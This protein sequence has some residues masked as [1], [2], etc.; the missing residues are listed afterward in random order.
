MQL[1][2]HEHEYGDEAGRRVDDKFCRKKLSTKSRTDSATLL[3]VAST[4]ES[5]RRRQ[6]TPLSCASADTAVQGVQREAGTCGR[7][8]GANGPFHDAS[9]APASC[10]RCSRCGGSGPAR[11]VAHEEEGYAQHENRCEIRLAS[12]SAFAQNVAFSEA[13]S[14]PG[15]GGRTCAEDCEGA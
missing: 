15:K 1:C 3:S 8:E 4:R 6:A 10:G 12:S 9:A 2:A 7:E 11:A 13:T 5:D 14:I